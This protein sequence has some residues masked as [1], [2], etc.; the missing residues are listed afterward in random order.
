MVWRKFWSTKSISS[1]LYWQAKNIL[2][3]PIYDL[4]NLST[5]DCI[6]IASIR[7]MVL[8]WYSHVIVQHNEDDYS[9]DF[10]GQASRFR[11]QTGGS[12]VDSHVG[13]CTLF[14]TP[15]SFHTYEWRLWLVSPGAEL[16]VSFACSPMIV[17]LFDFKVKFW[18]IYF[19]NWKS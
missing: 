17:F 14:D 1:F 4:Y 3:D 8:S 11:M 9:E 18:I 6:L 5:K 15:P 7:S 10:W 13:P 16:V 2:N 12:L 19:V